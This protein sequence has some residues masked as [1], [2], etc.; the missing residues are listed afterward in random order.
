MPFPY[1]FSAL[2]H[3]NNSHEVTTFYVRAKLDLD[4]N[5]STIASHCEIKLNKLLFYIF[6]L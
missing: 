4:N 3:N 2:S 1:S 5:G 6:S